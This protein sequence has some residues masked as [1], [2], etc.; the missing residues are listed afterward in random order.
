MGYE[1][2]NTLSSNSANVLEAE[3]RRRCPDQYLKD[4]EDILYVPQ[5][6]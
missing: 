5:Q 2:A 6:F 1:A 4:R 3:L